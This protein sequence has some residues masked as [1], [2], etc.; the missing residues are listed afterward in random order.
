[1][2]KKRVRETAGHGEGTKIPS[3]YCCRHVDGQ[4]ED[5]GEAELGGMSV[6]CVMAGE[7]ERL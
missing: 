1:M 2:T 3:L 6:L 5:T 4:V 7:P